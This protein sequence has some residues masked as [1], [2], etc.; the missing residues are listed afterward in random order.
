MW[1]E[2]YFNRCEYLNLKKKKIKSPGIETGDSVVCEIF[3]PEIFFFFF[4]DQFFFFTYL[5]VEGGIVVLDVT[6]K[7]E[8]FKKIN[9]TDETSKMFRDFF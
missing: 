5:G 6:K 1:R 8:L 3:C 4:H 7:N 9:T 2:K